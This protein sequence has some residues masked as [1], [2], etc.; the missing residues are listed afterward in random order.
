MPAHCAVS[1]R[2]LSAVNVAP[3]SAKYVSKTGDV[4]DVGLSMG[5]VH[6][7][8]T[9]F[10]WLMSTEGCPGLPGGARGA[11]SADWG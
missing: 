10:Q 3:K 5:A 7:T 6:F 2:G 1:R 8:K 9:C 4:S 11:H